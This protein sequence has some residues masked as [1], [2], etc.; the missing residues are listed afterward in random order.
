MAF[1]VSFKKNAKAQNQEK[2]IRENKQRC[3]QL[4]G[5]GGWNRRKGGKEGRGER[6][7]EDPALDP[8]RSLDNHKSN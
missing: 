4:G 6:G 2:T 8:I 7:E 1:V 5:G 3:G